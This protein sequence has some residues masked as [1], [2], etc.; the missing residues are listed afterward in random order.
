MSLKSL[1]I[2]MLNIMDDVCY[3]QKRGHN[4]FHKYRYAKDTDISTAFSKAFRDHQVFM[5]SSIVDR[6]CH[7]Y[8]TRGDKDSFLITVQLEVTFVD[9]ESGESFKT[10]FYGDG[11][12]SDDKAVYKAITGAQKYALMK[13][14]LVATG[15][16]PE[17]EEKVEVPSIDVN[18]LY[19]RLLSLAKDDIEAFRLAW[20]SLQLNEKQAMKPYINEFKQLADKAGKAGD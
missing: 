11:S 6:Q 4:T 16:D 19:Q 2:K 13:T 12:D 7:S 14:F 5:F 3:I 20:A 15:D 1:A 10:T 9:A 18:G 8:K 17:K